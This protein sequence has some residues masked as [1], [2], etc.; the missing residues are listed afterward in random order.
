MRLFKLFSLVIILAS[1]SMVSSAS[2]RTYYY[3]HDASAQTPRRYRIACETSSAVQKIPRYRVPSVD[4][5]TLNSRI[6]KPR[7][8]KLPKQKLK[9]QCTIPSVYQFTMMQTLSNCMTSR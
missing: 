4:I 3:D 9:R 5:P 8:V 6:D 2:C 7:H 1:G